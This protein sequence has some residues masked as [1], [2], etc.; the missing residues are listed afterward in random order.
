MRELMSQGI[1]GTLL[2]QVEAIVLTNTIDTLCY[3]SNKRISTL[4][5]IRECRP[6]VCL[7]EQ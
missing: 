4:G 5:T 1:Q 3:R 2:I 6:K 7:K